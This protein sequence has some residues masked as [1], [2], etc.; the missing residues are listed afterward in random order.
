M[1]KTCQD[2]GGLGAWVSPVL[3]GRWDSFH[4]TQAMEISIGKMLA[5]EDRGKHNLLFFNCKTVYVFNNNNNPLMFLTVSISM[6]EIK[7][8][9]YDR[10]WIQMIKHGSP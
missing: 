4:F 2:T 5:C 7:D 8:Y 6:R 9:D 10:L 3:A 1:C